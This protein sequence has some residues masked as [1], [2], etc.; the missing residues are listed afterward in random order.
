M[1]PALFGAVALLAAAGVVDVIGLIARSGPSVGD[2][3]SFD[4]AKD[5]PMEGDARLLVHRVDHFACVLDL[6]V[7]RQSGGSVIVE[8]RMPGENRGFHLHWAGERTSADPADCGRTA[9]LLVGHRDMDI[10]AMAAGGYGVA[11]KQRT[12]ASGSMA[13]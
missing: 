4:Q 6:N 11:A 7:L 2:I 5:V 3:I 12:A 10:L 1:G 8:A 9:D 13:F